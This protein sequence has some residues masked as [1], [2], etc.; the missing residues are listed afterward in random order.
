VD[1]GT[2][3]QRWRTTYTA[4]AVVQKVGTGLATA[5]TIAPVNPIVHITDAAITIVTITPPTGCATTGNG[6]VIT[7]IP[8]A[9]FT[10]NATGNIALASTAVINRALVIT[11]DNA[12][13]KWYPSY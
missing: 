12:T 8:D 7:L 6:C 1:L 11:Y 10:T 3:T 13:S 5:A 2:T 9:A 4:T